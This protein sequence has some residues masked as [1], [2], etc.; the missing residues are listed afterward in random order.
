MGAGFAA[1]TMVVVAA[2]LNG[3]ASLLGKPIGFRKMFAFYV[4]AGVIGVAGILVKMP[5]VFA[6]ESIDVRTSVA[7]FA[8][9]VAL[10]SPLGTALNMLDV[11]SIWV[12]VAT[13]I[14]Y[15][16]LSGLGT[17]KS[18]SVVVGLYV[19]WMLI[20]V[21]LAVMRSNLMSAS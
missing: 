5:L 13:C 4:Y 6:K 16:T 17:K 18:V 20:S 14:G 21:G 1:I 7:A 12:L 15:N 19:L 3:M 10:E 9:G 11:F 2:V 8:P